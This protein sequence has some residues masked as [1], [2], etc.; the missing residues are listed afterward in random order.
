MNEKDFSRTIVRDDLEKIKSLP[1]NTNRLG[2]SGT[3]N[4]ALP[5]E[6]TGRVSQGRGSPQLSDKETVMRLPQVGKA[7]AEAEDGEK[8]SRAAA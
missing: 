2:T 6:F 3:L 1:T 8:E 5:L 4:E 7:I